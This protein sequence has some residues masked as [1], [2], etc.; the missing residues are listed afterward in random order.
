[1]T[2]KCKEGGAEMKWAGQ[3]GRRSNHREARLFL[4]R[5]MEKI[6]DAEREDWACLKSQPSSKKNGGEKSQN[7]PMWIKCVP[8]SLNI[9]WVE[10]SQV[11]NGGGLEPQTEA[12]PQRGKLL[13]KSN[14]TSKLPPQRFL[15]LLIVK[16]YRFRFHR[17]RIL[18]ILYPCPGASVDTSEKYVTFHPTQ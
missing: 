10:G 4:P 12:F 11:H 5:P 13:F 7:I 9:S 15:F 8:C 17:V 3:I 18:H 1:M 16:L 6:F 14:I 2:P